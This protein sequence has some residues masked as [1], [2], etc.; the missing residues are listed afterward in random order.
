[1]VEAVV[2]RTPRVIVLPVVWNAEQESLANVATAAS[3]RHPNMIFP[4]AMQPI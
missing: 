3:P 2:E 4:K 1:M